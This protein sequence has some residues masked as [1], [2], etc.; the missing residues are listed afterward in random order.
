MS[1][2]SPTKELERFFNIDRAAK[3]F[4]PRGT[5]YPSQSSGIPMFARVKT[6]TSGIHHTRGVAQQKFVQIL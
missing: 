1:R 6:Q 2:K 4:Y 5:T 3:K